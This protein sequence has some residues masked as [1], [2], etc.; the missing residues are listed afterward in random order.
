MIL[1]TMY[2][3]S[4]GRDVLYF[5]Y[6]SLIFSAVPLAFGFLLP[7]SPKFLHSNKDFEKSKKSLNKI[8]R[9]NG[10]WD[11]TFSEINLEEAISRTTQS[12]IDKNAWFGLVDLWNDKLTLKNTLTMAY[13]W[14]FYTF[15]HH[16]LIFMMKYIPG[17][18]YTNGLLISIA[19]TSAPLLT[20]LIQNLLSSKQIYFL[21]SFL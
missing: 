21:F 9:L 16:C 2:L 14:G 15:G 6:L 10:Q 11:E 18:K 1:S 19:V 3:Y 12:G 20:R 5:V 4:G 13:L 8:A 7:E 17:D